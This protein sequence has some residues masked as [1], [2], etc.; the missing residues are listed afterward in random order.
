VHRCTGCCA[1]SPADAK[2]IIAAYV[3]ISIRSMIIIQHMVFSPDTLYVR[4]FWNG[5]CDEIR[6]WALF[7]KG[8]DIHVIF[9]SYKSVN[10]HS[11]L[12]DSLVRYGIIHDRKFCHNI[13]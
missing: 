2:G 10:Y 11:E 12:F 7:E 6:L 13:R 4:S 1:T 5:Y 8:G 3:I 9:S